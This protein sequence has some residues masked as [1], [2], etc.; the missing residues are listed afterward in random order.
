MGRWVQTDCPSLNR[1]GD[2]PLR[3]AAFIA[4]EI[5]AIFY[6]F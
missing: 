1:R 6:V 3:A 2:V 5:M 4:S